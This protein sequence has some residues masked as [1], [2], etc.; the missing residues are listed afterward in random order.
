MKPSLEL[1]FGQHLTMTP[2]LQQSIRLLQL[3]TLELQ[4]EIQQAVESNPLLEFDEGGEDEPDAP[5]AGVSE[6]PPPSMDSQADRGQS[7]DEEAPAARDESS[8]GLSMEREEGLSREDLPLDASWDDYFEPDGSTSFSAGDPEQEDRDLY[9]SRG[10]GNES[11]QDH[12]LSQV[13]L[14]SL[15]PRDRD[16]ATALVESIDDAGYLSEP[17]EGLLPALEADW[18]DIEL[19]EIEAVL[20]LI[21]QFDPAGVG[22]RSLSEALSIQLRQMPMDTPYRDIALRLTEEALDALGNREY[23]QIQKRLGIDEDTLKTVVRLIQ[24]LNPRPGSALSESSTDYVIPDIIVRRIGGQWRV[25]LNPEIAPRLRI[26][27]FY[28]SMIQR[29]SRNAD[30]SYLRA[31]LQEARWFIKS[32]QSRNE[33]LLNVGRAIVAHQ[34]DFL[35][36]GEMGMKPLVLREI[37]EELGLH[38]S[39]I[40]RVTTQ[41]YMH[42]PRGVF[43]FKY[44][45]SSHVGTADGGECSATAIRA[46]IKQLVAEENPA[47]PL[48]DSTIASTLEKRGIQVAR[49]TIAKY[50]EAMGI[51][52][53]SER[54]RLV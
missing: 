43:E 5:E 7:S 54:K 28:A 45:F 8:E 13:M 35:E 23:A 31:N 2:Q 6:A 44:F 50:R 19:G 49:R 39:T 26:N 16:I 42:T 27:S 18:P 51:A 22:A 12:L 40:S 14:S 3:S 4:T 47:K 1:R 46:M 29:G 25:D 20:H 30:S 17:I 24:S 33:T 15:G 48:S 41:K 32:L 11:L 38:E 53:S 21:Q 9:A 52:S 34:Q 36:Q 10:T 37:A